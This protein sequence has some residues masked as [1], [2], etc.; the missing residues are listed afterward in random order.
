MDA[1]TIIESKETLAQR[2]AEDGILIFRNQIDLHL[3]SE[4]IIEFQLI[5]EKVAERIKNMKRPLRDY[6]DIAERTPGRLDYRCGFTSP[7]FNEVGRP[8]IHL[9]KQ[10]SP[11]IDFRYYWGAIPS[12]GGSG[13]TNMHRDIYSILNT[14]QGMDLCSID[15]DLPAYY[16]TVLIPLM[17]ITSLNGPTE[18]IKGSHRSLHTDENEEKIIAPLL[19]PGDFLV[20]DGRTMHRGSANQSSQERVLA[21][22]TFIAN[23]YH[24]QTFTINDYLFPELAIKGF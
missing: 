8:I 7:I 15:R 2:M 3:I 21:Y 16:L 11:L 12:A 5:R 1:R 18:F 14:T 20:F 17:E 6:T 4:M 19:S 23:W 9:I 10:I 13:P 24:D 22:M